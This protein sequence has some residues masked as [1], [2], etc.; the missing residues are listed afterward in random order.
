VVSGSAQISFSGISGVPSGLVSGS[1]QISFGS[2]SGVPS[3]LVS[4]SSQITL[5]STTGFGS[6]LNQGVLTS[7]SPSFAGLTTTGLVTMSRSAGAT[8]LDMATNDNYASMRVI[9]NQVTSGGNADGMYIGYQNGN[10]GVTRIFGGGATSGGIAV[11]GS[12]VNNVTIAGNIVLNASNYTSYAMQ[13]A[14]YSANQNL[15]T[16][17]SPT[18]DSPYFS[19]AVSHNTSSSR[20]KYNVYGSSGTY[21]IGMQSGI[22]Y[23]GLSDWGMTFQFNNDNVRGFWWGDDGHSVNQGA[24]A[25]TTHGYLT[26]ARGARIGY[27]ESDT[28]TPTLPLQVYGSGGVVVDIQGASGQLFSVTDD[29]TGDIFSVSDIS[30]MPLLNVNAT[31]GTGFGFTAFPLVNN[32]YDLGTSALRWANVYTNDLHLSNEGKNGGNDIDGTTGNWTI[33]EG[34]EQLYIINNKN[35]KKFR[36][37]LTEI[38]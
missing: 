35:G 3:G 36:I 19:G 13:G 8:G 28:T 14:G 7:S 15:N 26:L 10:S 4:G 31:T 23:G 12:G 11:N 5:S 32:L 18:F 29:L 33:Q 37:N 9:A 38:E 34:A 21:C 27:G 20:N 6:Y 1:S 24:M 16:T 22:G 25:L 30:G 17:S 2:I